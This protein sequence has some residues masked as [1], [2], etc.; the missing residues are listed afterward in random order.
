MALFCLCWL[1]ILGGI[2]DWLKLTAGRRSGTR[3]GLRL[4]EK[5]VFQVAL[6]AL[7]AIFILRA[8]E[9]NVESPRWLDVEATHS[10]YYNV[11]S[12]PF[13]KQGIVLATPVFALITII[14]IAHRLSTIRKA[15]T[16]F[17]PSSRPNASGR[18]FL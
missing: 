15:D 17:Q 18:V 7:L 4:W 2:D 16:S 12:I 5:L 8:G 1:A 9:G 3:D 13:Y 11:L 6:G 14:V 10:P